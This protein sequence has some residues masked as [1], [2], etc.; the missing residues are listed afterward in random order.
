MELPS[1]I[2]DFASLPIYN[3]RDCLLY[4]LDATSVQLSEMVHTLW[5]RYPYARLHRKNLPYKNRAVRTDRDI[6]GLIFVGEAPEFCN[7][8]DDDPYESYAVLP[9]LIGLITQFTNGPATP[10]SY[11]KPRY[12]AWSLDEHFYDGLKNDT[13][14]QRW[15]WFDKALRKAIEHILQRSR[16]GQVGRIIFP[17]GLGKACGQYLTSGER[18]IWETKYFPVMCKLAQKLQERGID[19]LMICPVNNDTPT[20][21]PTHG[22]FRHKI[23]RMAIPPVS[24]NDKD[25]VSTVGPAADVRED[26]SAVVEDDP[27]TGAMSVTVGDEVL[28]I[29]EDDDNEDKEKMEMEYNEDEIRKAVESIL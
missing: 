1:L 6:P 22:I 8:M 4:D 2:G 16:R 11:K 7:R 12:E 19:T 17:Y 10:S 18:N 5:E 28:T 14:Y 26:G 25:S 24:T 3:N 23:P 15:R 29:V 27:S 13:E 20:R 9:H 21:S